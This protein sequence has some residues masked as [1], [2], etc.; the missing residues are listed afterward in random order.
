MR[1]HAVGLFAAAF[2]ATGVL[3]AFFSPVGEAFRLFPGPMAAFT[4]LALL[5]GASLGFGA[6]RGSSAPR[7]GRIRPR[8]PSRSRLRALSEEKAWCA[9]ACVL[10]D[11][12]AIVGDRE[13]PF[14]TASEEAGEGVFFEAGTDFAGNRLCTLADPWRRFLSRP[15][16]LRLLKKR[17]GVS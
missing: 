12:V 15:R 5:A 16:N 8:R 10:G 1:E 7:H 17:A 4:S 11:G 14:V 13:A 9:L 2:S 3:S 6:G